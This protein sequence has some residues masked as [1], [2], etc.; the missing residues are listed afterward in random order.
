MKQALLLLG[1]ALCFTAVACE[2]PNQPETPV[3]GKQR[4]DE[5]AMVVGDPTSA[6]Q[7]T[8]TSGER[9]FFDDPGC[10]AAYVAGHHPSVRSMW[11]RTG[12]GAWVDARSAR[13]ATGATTPMDYGFRVADDG[14]AVWSDLEKA[15]AS[16]AKRE[17][18]R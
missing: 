13:F 14:G 5:C 1:A 10:L 6:A 7:L 3:W 11:V 18:V 9:H 17:V 12:A 15:A 2:N 8:T 16:R 4:C